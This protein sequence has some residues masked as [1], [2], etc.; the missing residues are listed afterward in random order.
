[1]RGII[2]VVLF[3]L[4]VQ[5]ASALYVQGFGYE[6]KAPYHS[7]IIFVPG[8][9]GSAL[10]DNNRWTMADNLWPGNPQEDRMELALKD[11]GKTPVIEG[12]DIEP[13]YVLRTV[14]GFK[15]IYTGFYD[16]MNT[17]TPYTFNG[18]VGGL[19]YQGKAYFDHPYDFRLPTDDQLYKIEKSLDKKVKEVLKET[20]SDKVILVAHS[21]GGLQAKMYAAENPDKVAGVIF[22]SS[23]LN[24]APRGFQ[25]LT[26]G[27]N[28]D[29]TA[30]ITINHVWEIGHNWP[31]VFHLSPNHEFTTKDGSLVSLDETFLKGINYQQ[32]R[33]IPSQDFAE[34]RD[35]GITSQGEVTKFLEQKYSGLSKGIYA[36]TKAFRQKFDNLKVDDSIR[37][38]IIH[39]DNKNTTQQFVV[40][41]EIFT[42]YETYD[43]DQMIT[44]P[45]GLS[46]PLAF[47]F[48]FTARRFVRVDSLEGDETVHKK[49][50]QWD[51][52][53]STES[54]N[55]GHMDMASQPETMDKLMAIVEEINHDKRDG[56]WLKAIKSIAIE[57]LKSAEQMSA[58][59]AV[60]QSEAYGQAI[61]AENEKEAKD[62][63]WISTLL[64]DLRGRGAYV[65]FDKLI[66]GKYNTVQIIVP[67]LG[68][69]NDKDTD[70]KA[71]FALESYALTDVNIG[72]AKPATYKVT[73]DKETFLKLASGE[74]R[75]KEAWNNGKIEVS[76]GLKENLLLW[77]GK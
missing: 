26:E 72:T 36:Q 24:G 16:Y 2:L 11:D 18:Y 55:Y 4:M 40:K 45:D 1:M 64:Q 6:A 47:P 65:F 31:G 9:M 38:A 48:Q 74:M 67:G 66:D 41:D 29:A 71:Y 70:F 61:K 17:K 12:S 35:A 53:T 28:F 13:K 75:L 69:Y 76:G 59:I 52:A 56:E 30:L 60:G 58:D 20:K 44:G 77:V 39:G 8:I 10:D 34:M 46:M 15:K 3:L 23:P 5:G 27:Y 49:G 51:R 21:M 32:A 62:E 14:W 42:S 7:P 43:T 50:F 63:G 25:S 19:T 54:V 33:H 57:N 22:L 73:I 37:I 68:N